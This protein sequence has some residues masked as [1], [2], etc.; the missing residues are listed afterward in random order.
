M[1]A[2]DLFPVAR[3]LYEYIAPSD[4]GINWT[5][6]AAKNAADPYNSAYIYEYLIPA[7]EQASAVYKT[8]DIDISGIADTEPGFLDFFNATKQSEKNGLSGFLASNPVLSAVLPGGLLIQATPHMLKALIATMYWSATN[9]AFA[10]I[11]IKDKATQPFSIHMMD[12]DNNAIMHHADQVVMLFKLITFLDSWKITTPIKKSGLKGTELGNPLVAIVIAVVAV[13]MIIAAA[14]VLIIE[15]RKTNELRA[16]V[17][18]EKLDVMRKTCAENQDPKVQVECAKG[19]T[20]EDLNGGT[21]AASIGAGVSRGIEKLTT[22]LAVGAG[23]YLLI[24]LGLPM[25]TGSIAKKV[26]HKEA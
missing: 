13:V 4:L 21:L 1:D 2:S 14:I 8:L 3:K 15:V 24:T 20:A 22:Y 17:V 26:T 10:H 11:A 25:L 19:P 16:Q 12:L 9:G 18:A 6:L 7:W 23:L 5:A